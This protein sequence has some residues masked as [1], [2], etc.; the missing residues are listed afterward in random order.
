MRETSQ[1]M[2]VILRGIVRV[3][4][5]EGRIAGR[6]MHHLLAVHHVAHGAVRTVRAAGTCSIR[7]VDHWLYYPPPRVNKPVVDLKYRQASVL[8]QLLLLVLRRVRMR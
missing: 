5:V 7:L 3:L 1:M 8:R 6:S 4:V 2:S